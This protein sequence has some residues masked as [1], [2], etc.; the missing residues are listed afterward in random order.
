M[1]LNMAH[2]A[3]YSMNRG[4][5]FPV[6]DAIVLDSKIINQTNLKA[7]SKEEAQSHTFIVT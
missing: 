7:L 3:K 5:T 4:P 6:R 2:C 1:Y